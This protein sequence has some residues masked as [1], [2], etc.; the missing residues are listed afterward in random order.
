[1]S[2]VSAIWLLT[3]LFLL[4]H[5]LPIDAQNE[6]TAAKSC[7]EFTSIALDVD[8]F[9]G[10]WYEV[11]RQPSNG[12]A[13]IQTI[14][15]DTGLDTVY[16]QTR[17]SYMYD[18]TW[19]SPYIVAVVTALNMTTSPSPNGY[20]APFLLGNFL[21]PWTTYKILSTDYENYALVCGFT[22]AT[23]F[24]LIMTRERQSKQQLFDAFEVALDPIYSNII[25]SSLS[26]V[27]QNA[28]CLPS[29]AS[30]F[31][32]LTTFNSLGM[33]FIIYVLGK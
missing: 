10:T 21:L 29:S 19:I 33:L 1:M 2:S 6:T 31:K 12:H 7:R 4:F 30:T 3:S 28:T 18:N 8:K 27:M 14:L 24:G 9:M 23:S 16:I 15:T 22:N 13:C 25:N 11:A 20:T 26:F 32:I 17:Y 5:V